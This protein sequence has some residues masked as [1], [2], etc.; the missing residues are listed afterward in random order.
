MPSTKIINVLK[1][2]SFEELLDIFRDAPAQEVIFVLPKKTKAFQAEGHFLILDKEAKITGKT[3]SFLT[4]NPDV[5]D[6]AKKF[7]F[8]VLMPR[9]KP[10]AKKKSAPA[11]K[12]VTQVDKNESKGHDLLDDLASDKKYFDFLEKETGHEP[13]P[14]VA[15]VDIETEEVEG[16]QEEPEI[17]PIVAKAKKSMADVVR[18]KV[19]TKI[20][21]HQSKFFRSRP[22]ISTIV[23]G[24]IVVLGFVV[25]AVTGTAKIEIRP[26]KHPLNLQFKTTASNKYAVVDTNFNR[27]PGQFFE[28][29]ETVSGEYQATGERDVAQKAKGKITVYNRLTSAQPLVAT[30]RFE[31][32]SGLIFRS[33]SSV[34]VPAAR[35]S[36]PGSVEVNVIADR[37]D[38]AYNVPAGDFN[39]PAFREKGD[40]QRYQNVFGQSKEAMRGG[41]SGKAKVITEADYNRAKEDLTAQLK[42]KL[43]ASLKS[44]VA[45]LKLVSDPSPAIDAPESSAQVDDALDSFQ[46][47]LSGT[48]KT[49][50]FKEDDIVSLIK[51]RVQ[52]SN[53][54]DIV[55][56]K[57]QISYVTPKF[58]SESGMVEFT[59][60]VK[61][62]A[63]GK[64]DSGKIATELAGRKEDQIREYLQGLAE[65]KSAKV[66]LSPFWVTRVPRDATSVK[67]EIIYE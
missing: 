3:V 31:S 21:G 28:I 33:L 65:V 42:A 63:F 58:N 7:K 56:E 34:V 20:W 22:W 25:Y 59:V 10:A 24:V 57:I 52:K 19:K 26:M 60:E 43:E 51:A 50:G 67:T 37:A 39:I 17:I 2:D 8:D 12:I 62:S 23:V 16:P 35:G 61:G 54:L 36:T 4:S 13:I 38:A 40:T 27:V 14:Q 53:N 46:V 32:S 9:S 45:G 1:D 64:V 55:P 30:T 6:F 15:K 48:I 5:N 44:E 41:T 11:I 29:A 49:V 47:S 66:L 18:P